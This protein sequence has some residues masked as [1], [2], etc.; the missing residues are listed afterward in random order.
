MN[1]VLKPGG[2]IAC[3]ETSQPEIPVY[4]Q[5]F[6]FYFKFIMPLFGKFLQKVIRNIHGYKNLQ[7]DFPGMKNLLNYSQRQV[8]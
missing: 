8:L 2:M 3:L 7:N 5:L 6:R 1:R 4:R